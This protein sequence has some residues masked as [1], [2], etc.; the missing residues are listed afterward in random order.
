M[1]GRDACNGRHYHKDSIINNLT[2]MNLTFNQ[3]AARSTNSPGGRSRASL[4]YAAP[5]HPRTMRF[6]TSSA[7][8][9][10]GDVPFSRP[11]PT[12]FSPENIRL[13]KFDV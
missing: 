9:Q 8:Q 12:I 1:P 5:V 10:G 11:R 4:R 6:C 13:Q 2:E 7:S 3:V